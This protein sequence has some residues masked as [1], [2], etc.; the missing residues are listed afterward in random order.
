MVTFNRNALYLMLQ[1]IQDYTTN[2]ET[3]LFLEQNSANTADTEIV[4]S[5]RIMLCECGW[6]Q[7]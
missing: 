7:Q 1:C 2:K 5:F 4:T 6:E 3:S